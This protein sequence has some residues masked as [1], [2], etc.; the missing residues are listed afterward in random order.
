MHGVVALTGQ[1][2]PAR[3]AV[4][5]SLA[6]HG[7]LQ[8]NNLGLKRCDYLFRLGE[9]KPKI[10]QVRLLIAFDAGHLNLRHDPRPKLRHQFHPPYQLRHQTYPLP[11]SPEP[12]PTLQPPR[13]LNALHS[14]LLTPPVPTTLN[15]SADRSPARRSGSSEVSVVADELANVPH[16]DPRT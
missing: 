3:R 16:L 13:I 15:V 10:S 6:N 12:S 5:T 7:H 4:A 2:V 11:V 8:G 9:T 14:D 1:L